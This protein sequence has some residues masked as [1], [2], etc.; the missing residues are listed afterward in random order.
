MFR[1]VLKNYAIAPLAIGRCHAY[2]VYGAFVD[3]DLHGRQGARLRFGTY[4]ASVVRD[5]P[6]AN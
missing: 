4:I 5:D 1:A 3:G 2:V 6:T